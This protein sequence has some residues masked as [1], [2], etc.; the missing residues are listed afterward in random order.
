MLFCKEL[1]R[2]NLRL[3]FASCIIFVIL[4]NL[5]Y[6]LSTPITQCPGV[7]SFEKLTRSLPNPDKYSSTG[8][9]YNEPEPITSECVKAC[10]ELPTCSGLLL[11]YS[12]SNCVSFDGLPDLEQQLDDDFV[13]TH[14]A[15]NFFQKVC[16]PDVEDKFCGSS[17]WTLERIS[18]AFLDGFV[19]KDLTTNS[20]VECSK[21]CLTESSFICRSASYDQISRR[22]FMTT[23]SRRTQP[24][25]FRHPFNVSSAS[26]VYMENHCVPNA[27]EMTCAFKRK[28]DK[29][30]TSM[31]ALTFAKNI[32]ECERDCRSESKFSCRSYSYQDLK[33][34]LSSD[35][36]ISLGA[37]NEAGDS[38]GSH[39]GELV[40][41][42]DDCVNGRYFYEKIIGYSL[43]TAE[44]E[45]MKDVI[46]RSSGLTP[47]S[48]DCVNNCDQIGLLCRAAVMDHSHSSCSKLDR[49]S[50]GRSSELIPVPD[51]TFMEKTCLV[52][53]ETD[54]QGVVF[55]RIPGYEFQS[56][57][58]LKTY[59]GVTSRQECE[60]KCLTHNALIRNKRQTDVE[61]HGNELERM[62]NN[63]HSSRL[64]L[65]KDNQDKEE[66]ES[67]S[68]SCKSMTYN[69]ATTDCRLSNQ[70][71]LFHP[72]VSSIHGHKSS[73][74]ENLCLFQDNRKRRNDD[75][76]LVEGDLS[77]T[78]CFFQ[79]FPG[80]SVIFVESSFMSVPT[81]QECEKNCLD[82]PIC[83]S[84]S[85][86]RSNGECLLSRESQRLPNVVVIKPSD[87]HDY[88]EMNC[89]SK[90]V[91]AT[92]ESP[93]S[94]AVTFMTDSLTIANMTTT[95]S[96]IVTE[97][98]TEG[99]SPTTG[100]SVTPINVTVTQPT[101]STETSSMTPD[102]NV[103]STPTKDPD[104]SVTQSVTTSSDSPVS[105]A[106]ETVTSSTSSSD[107]T[108]ISQSPTISV[109]E[110]ITS[111]STDDT[112]NSESST[113]AVIVSSSKS[114]TG[115]NSSIPE[116]KDPESTASTSSTSEA[117]TPT[118]DTS[119]PSTPIDPTS[120]SS[121]VT[122]SLS[123]P[124]TVTTPVVNVTSPVTEISNTTTD[125]T[126][127]TSTT[128]K[129]TQTDSPFN[130]TQT[131][132]S[133][134]PSG[135]SLLLLS[136]VSS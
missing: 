18:G 95:E 4:C 35:D 33:C 123:I 121:S 91:S 132:S 104:G 120:S 86:S 48:T 55:Q 76:S 62:T 52:M 51:K 136:N 109:N 42:R 110:T 67:G 34:K 93:T 19:T 63:S 113:E 116:T 129:T 15:V 30:V 130:E 108:S 64:I 22:C 54:C 87:S 133:T 127:S 66:G 105:T 3:N 83:Y 97:V 90:E 58:Y 112:S 79:Q 102:S 92:T 96:S 7:I 77:K 75:G 59:S 6:I 21:L 14:D 61:H 53:T 12:K 98:T 84:F 88:Y 46:A 9:L 24:Q 36:R 65:E 44:E 16:Y 41:S 26:W 45:D 78:P 49:N 47:F 106:S 85:Y 89:T 94:P 28:Q 119:S 38:V 70:S 117:V 100:P 118:T 73:H 13:P 17:L 5:H 115:D 57:A 135:K 126:T 27:F 101:I 99:S 60:Q 11:D 56:E 68:F 20:R 71:F 122:E 131:T 25:A 81:V 1:L 10:K 29:A 69:E 39:Y 2:F 107:A 103:T 124:V 128:Q 8:M 74:L 32:S 37:I 23:E 50:Q 114:P 80:H 43:S 111:S 125:V 31:D 40:C 134:T 82:N 72:L